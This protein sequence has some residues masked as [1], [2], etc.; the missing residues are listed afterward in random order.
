ME[1]AL[2]FRRFLTKAELDKA[3][4]GLLGLVEGVAMDGRVSD[5]EVSFL[6]LWLADHQRWRDVH[7]FTELV[8]LVEQAVQ[9]GVLTDEER[10]DLR[11]L[12]DKLRSEQYFCQV[13]GDMQRLHAILGGIAADRVVTA[14]ELRGLSAW[15][16][17]HAHLQR[18][19]PFDEIQSV[20][21]G[22]LRDGRVDPR[23]HDLMLQFFSEFTPILDD[24]ALTQPLVAVDQQ[25]VGLCAVCPEI[26]FAG[27]TFCFTGASTR[28]TRSSFHDL[29]RELGGKPLD[30]VTKKLDYLIIGADGNACWAFAAYGR[31]VERAVELRR[32]GAKLLL[33]HENDF[34]DA[35]QDA[36]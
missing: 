15:M 32:Q 9:D 35:V 28:M 13:T 34:H 7:P 27:A 21:T 6:R 2:D 33:V 14:E 1:A 3:I 19:W 16:D 18:C 29:V 31:K 25:L 36:R 30:S 20:V 12:C 22:V 8:P 17:D 11:W 23:E 10:E 4:N 5:S 24:R 26:S